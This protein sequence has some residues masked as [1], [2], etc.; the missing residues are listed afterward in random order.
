MEG[1]YGNDTYIFNL[2]DGQDKICEYDTASGNKD[3]STLSNTQVE[4]LI[5]AMA[6]FTQDNGMSWSQAIQDKPQDV[7]DILSQFWVRQSE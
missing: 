1:G 7:Q 2:G 3:T 5:Q 4:Q 6:G